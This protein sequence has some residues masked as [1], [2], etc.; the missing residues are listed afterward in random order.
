LLWAL[1]PATAQELAAPPALDD[2]WAVAAPAEAGFDPAALAALG[3]ELAAGDFGNIHAVLAVH[4]GRLVFERYFAGP[5][6]LWGD[7]I[8][9]VAFDAGTLHDLRSVTKSVTALLVGIAL[10]AEAAAALDRPVT[11]FFPDLTDSFAPGL[12]QVT[13]HHVLTMT[14]GLEWNEMEVPYT[15][16]E[17][18][19]IRMIYARDPVA[20]VLARPVREP[21]GSRWYYSGGLT[22]VLAGLTE[23]R[24]GQRLDD[25]ARAV[26][27]EPLGITDWAWLGSRAWDDGM[28]SGASGLRLTARGLAKIGRLVLDGGRWQGRQVVPEEWLRRALTR[29]V[30]R[31]PWSPDG[32]IGYGYQW[33]PGQLEG[34]G[35]GGG[36]TIWGA[37]GL[38]QQR[39]YVLPERKLVFVVFAGLYKQR[40]NRSG[41][42]IARRL[43]AAHRTH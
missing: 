32:T 16:S 38:G 11:T 20:M 18:D 15:S 22:Q 10:G 25:Y 39:L 1:P 13:L 40:S 19:E 5:D 30:A 37:V 41:M 28:P 17:N 21:P 14:A 36:L 27:F 3:E 33:Y 4:D 35:S 42:A 12:E 7:P 31:I 43:L 26:L 29:H 2:G 9:R 24:V 6:E 8:G 34:D 23:R